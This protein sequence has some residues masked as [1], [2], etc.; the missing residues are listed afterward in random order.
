MGMFQAAFLAW[1]THSSSASHLTPQDGLLP[2]RPGVGD[3]HSERGLIWGVHTVWTHLG[4]LH[5]SS[6]DSFDF[7]TREFKSKPNT[8]R[9][10]YGK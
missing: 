8:N 10:F 5:T 7:Q 4:V 3:T 6:V 1:I 9:R 2:R